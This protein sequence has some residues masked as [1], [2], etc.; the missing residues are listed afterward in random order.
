MILRRTNINDVKCIY[1]ISQSLDT[2]QNTFIKPTLQSIKDRLKHS[3]ISIDAGKIVGFVL[4]DFKKFGTERP[5]WVIDT[6]VSLQPKIGT[7]MLNNIQIREYYTCI[8]DKN[9]RSKKLFSKFGFTK[10]DNFK[11]QG[12]DRGRYSQRLL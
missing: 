10:Y 6:I 3:Y 9:E 11:I 1:Q 8:A 4:I 5:V 7:F 12:F 2:N